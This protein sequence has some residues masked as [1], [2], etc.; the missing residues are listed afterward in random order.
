MPAA[1][2]RPGLHSAVSAFSCVVAACLALMSFL[3][4]GTCYKLFHMF[5]YDTTTCSAS[6]S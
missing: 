2:G 5:K 1:V 4:K 3:E 6:L